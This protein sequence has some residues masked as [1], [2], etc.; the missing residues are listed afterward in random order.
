MVEFALM[1]LLF[2]AVVFSVMDT[3]RLLFQ[4][5]SVT[6]AAAVTARYAALHGATAAANGKASVGPGDDAA[7]KAI[8]L[9]STSW[10]SSSGLTV[11]GVWAPANNNKGSRVSVTVT[12]AASPVVGLLWPG[13]LVINL[14]DTATATIQY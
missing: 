4:R 9:Q 3:A 10:L 6:Q 14:Q 11:H 8:A 7:L 13:A 12:Y 5:A 2:F 1:A